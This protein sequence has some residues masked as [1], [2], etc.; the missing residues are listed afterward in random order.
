MITIIEQSN[1]RI[2]A[3]L[4][5]DMFRLRAKIFRDRLSW[6]VCV[7]DG[8]EKDEFDDQDPLYLIHSTDGAVTACC[9]LLPTTG[10]TLISKFFSDTLP[11]AASLSAP[12]IW[13]CTRFCVDYKAL[14]REGAQ[15]AATVCGTLLTQIGV[16]ALKS[17]IE[18]VLGNFDELILRLYRKIGCEVEILGCT[19]R[20]GRP[21]YLGSFPI[22]QEIVNVGLERFP[23]SPESVVR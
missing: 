8:L 9:R 17:G 6:D 3:D 20:Y 21:V 13:E 10:P 19:R 18:T 23:S 2:H 15:T 12:S 11:D 7:R 1:A 4:L 16:L 22:S 14:G 5:R